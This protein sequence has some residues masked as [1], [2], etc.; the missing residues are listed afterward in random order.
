MAK[1]IPV[2]PPQI[3]QSKLPGGGIRLS[4]KPFLE[5]K[6][7]SMEITTE[8]AAVQAGRA[9]Q[10]KTRFT[11]VPPTYP[12]RNVDVMTWV[13]AIRA[14]QEEARTVIEKMKP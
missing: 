14:M 11:A 10:A 1:K 7:A 9:P 12:L 6:L 13:E 3:E 2:K 8:I 4:I 5:Q